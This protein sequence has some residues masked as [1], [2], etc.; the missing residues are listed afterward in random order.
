M[1]TQAVSAR[2]EIADNECHAP[3]PGTQRKTGQLRLNDRDCLSNRSHR[4]Q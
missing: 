3:A 1:V 4:L 2:A